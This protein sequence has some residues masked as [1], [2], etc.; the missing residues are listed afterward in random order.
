M[1][2]DTHTGKTLEGVKTTILVSRCRHLCY[3]LLIMLDLKPFASLVFIA[4]VLCC[5]NFCTE[6]PYRFSRAGLN[7]DTGVSTMYVSE[8]N[9]VLELISTATDDQLH[10]VR[11]TSELDIYSGCTL[12]SL[13]VL[14][15]QGWRNISSQG[16][17]LTPAG[18]GNSRRYIQVCLSVCLLLRLSYVVSSIYYISLSILV[19]HVSNV[20]GVR[21]E[22]HLKV[23]VLLHQ[24]Y[25]PL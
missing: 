10:V 25:C 2:S 15:H 20:S 5:S 13:E 12:Q 21:S 19:F 9:G 1:T 23:S 6:C 17:A 7:S 16:F 11:G 14:T 18:S 3:E 22:C 8:T 24:E 4:I